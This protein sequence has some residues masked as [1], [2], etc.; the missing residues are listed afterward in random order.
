[1]KS[2]L[3]YSVVTPCSLVIRTHGIVEQLIVRRDV[4]NLIRDIHVPVNAARGPVRGSPPPTLSSS[5]TAKGVFF[6]SDKKC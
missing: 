5:R 3:R 4:F 6:S 2:V 1:M